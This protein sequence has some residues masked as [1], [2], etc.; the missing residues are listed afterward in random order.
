MENKITSLHLRLNFYLRLNEHI[1]YHFTYIE[2]LIN[3]KIDQLFWLNYFSL[4]KL[5]VFFFI[6]FKIF[7]IIS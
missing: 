3:S 4:D 2:Y 6:K 7:E 5:S 1:T